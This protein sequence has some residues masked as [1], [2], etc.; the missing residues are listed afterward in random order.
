MPISVQKCEMFGK[1]LKIEFWN[2]IQKGQNQYINVF[3]K[4]VVSDSQNYR[5]FKSKD[6]KNKSFRKIFIKSK[7]LRK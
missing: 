3:Y 4:T 2:K 6:L 7:F 5:L 1:P